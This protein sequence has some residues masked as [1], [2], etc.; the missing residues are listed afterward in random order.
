MACGVCMGI[1]SDQCPVCGK[2]AEPVEC[3]RCRGTGH[4]C[5]AED[6]ATGKVTE[7]TPVAY[8]ILPP[9]EDMARSMGLRYCQ[10]EIEKCPECCGEGVVYPDDT[11]EDFFDED[12]AMERYYER[13]YGNG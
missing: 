4:I 10:G 9:T 1:N 11:G 2:N 6:L 13:K 3:S 7:V 8:S 5:H 12:A